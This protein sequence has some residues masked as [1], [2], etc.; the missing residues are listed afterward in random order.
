MFCKAVGVTFKQLILVT[1]LLTKTFKNKYQ[2]FISE[3][4]SDSLALVVRGAS[5][6]SGQAMHSI[7]TNAGGCF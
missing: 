4:A 1:D 5:A 6:M 7:F 2:M 3:V